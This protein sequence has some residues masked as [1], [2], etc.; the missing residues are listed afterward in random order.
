VLSEYE[1]TEILSFIGS[2]HFG[3]HGRALVDG[4]RFAPN[5]PIVKEDLSKNLEDGIELPPHLGSGF[6]FWSDSE[7]YRSDT[8]TGPLRPAGKTPKRVY[9]VGLGPSFVLLWTSRTEKVVWSLEGQKAV[10]SPYPSLVDAATLKDGRSALWLEPHVLM[11]RGSGQKDYVAINHPD[12][13]VAG[14]DVQGDDFVI[15][16]ANGSSYGVDEHGKL[17]PHRLEE[18][19]I[20]YLRAA[21]LA[22]LPLEGDVA[23]GMYKGMFAKVSLR[24]GRILAKL[25]PVLPELEQCRFL[26]TRDDAIALCGAKDRSL[27]VVRGFSAFAPKVERRF[28]EAV[29]FVG[30]A[31]S[32]LKLGS[33]DDRIEETYQAVCIRNDSGEWNETKLT[34]TLP[35]QGHRSDSEPWVSWWIP[36][37]Q[38]HALGIV[39]GSNPGLYDTKTGT[40]APFAKGADLR[41][42]SELE[43]D[44]SG[45]NEGLV[46]FPDATI[47][48]YTLDGPRHWRRDGRAIDIRSLHGIGHSGPNALA[49]MGEHLWQSTDYGQNWQR[50][51][52]PPTTDS[53]ERCWAGG[54]IFGHW[55]RLGFPTSSVAPTVPSTNLTLGS[56]TQSTNDVYIPSDEA[57]EYGRL[58]FGAEGRALVAGVRVAPNEPMCV[59]VPTT[60]T[61]GTQ[62]PAHLGGGFLFWTDHEFHHSET[63]TGPLTL[64]G[65]LPIP[66]EIKKA[67]FGPSALVFHMKT[68]GRFAWSPLTKQLAPMPEKGLIDIATLADG[69]VAVFKEPGELWLKGKGQREFVQYR[70]R[71][72]FYVHGLDV[73]SQTLTIHAHPYPRMD[74]YTLDPQGQLLSVRVK[75]PLG[76]GHHPPITRA[77][78][79]RN[80]VPLGPRTVLAWDVDKV[81]KLDLYS[82]HILD[83]SD[84]VLIG[85]SQQCELYP[86][87]ND[88]LAFCTGSQVRVFA[89][90]GALRPRIERVF[91]AG[92]RLYEGAE[93]ALVK[94]GGCDDE[95][96]E[97]SIQV[98]VR[99]PSGAWHSVELSSTFLGHSARVV[100]WIPRSKAGPL[101]VVDANPPGIYDTDTRHFMAF[102]AESAKELLGLLQ[103]GKVSVLPNGN[104]A[105]YSEKGPWQCTPEGKLLRPAEALYGLKWQGANAL[106][107]N[108]TRSLVQSTDYGVTWQA[109]SPP[110]NL[111]GHVA[112][113][114]CGFAG[115]EVSDSNLV[116][117]G[118]SSDAGCEGSTWYRIGYP[119]TKLDLPNETINPT[120]A[121]APVIPL[122]ECVTHGPS[123]Q[124]SAVSMPAASSRIGYVDWSRTDV[125]EGPA[126]VQAQ[127][128][129]D[130]SWDGHRPLARQPLIYRLFFDNPVAHRIDLDWNPL[131]RL[132]MKPEE[133]D[134][135]SVVS[136]GPALPVLSE[137]PEVTAGMFLATR[138]YSTVVGVHVK[139]NHAVSIRPVFPGT[140]TSVAENRAGQLLYLMKADNEFELYREGQKIPPAIH[141]TPLGFHA[142]HPEAVAF[143]PDGN[144]GVLRIWS[145]LPATENDPALVLMPGKP[146]VALAPWSTLQLGPCDGQ[147][148]YRSIVTLKGWLGL[149]IN[150]VA[151]VDTTITALA[152]WNE[153]RVCV[154]AVESLTWLPV[155]VNDTVRANLQFTATFGKVQRAY[156]SNPGFGVQYVQPL[157]CK[158]ENH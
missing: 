92:S 30:E 65:H 131:R 76:L 155:V 81:V 35:R 151:S 5:E 150:G 18:I 60:L 124:A 48:G 147:P 12:M 54:C 158:L 75:D 145:L 59:D 37:R 109:V 22:G 43:L 6:L 89:G 57:V 107:V 157:S 27:V 102:S 113:K 141:A 121:P 68:G 114:S 62:V 11:I 32:L 71:T 28:R 106:A 8:F 140:L 10:E 117:D 47:G 137:Q 122:I 45:I 126:P 26:K 154:E 90:L 82:G 136:T 13:V 128:A 36:T 85:F 100:G 51:R 123:K 77:D 94:D 119:T 25:E 67:S 135:S 55:Y 66:G 73:V 15:R 38:G 34:Q 72:G 105:G 50:V 41:N 24:S 49:S 111:Q 101:A 17:V 4:V 78:A 103:W 44:R 16:M 95:A 120:R 39:L 104:I 56:K 58:H 80:G 97:G 129:V 152:H 42:L 29:F 88:V 142:P 79:F 143:G 84:S 144:P 64:V 31:G 21:A 108:G 132:M 91:P 134:L 19:S 1:P 93:G 69:R 74:D 14:I 7:L 153:N 125:E 40:I 83:A 118:T 116:C 2:Y 46:E 149:T 115:C 156:A 99:D 112:P 9:R 98:C 146:P 33:C 138:R 52:P 96:K 133:W 148:G 70:E 130:I 110:R 63:F 87:S 53:V 20:N 86:T 3:G 139:L 23:L 127:A 61:G